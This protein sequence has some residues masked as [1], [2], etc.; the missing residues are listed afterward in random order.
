MLPLLHQRQGVRD[1]VGLS[2]SER[3][4]NMRDALMSVSGGEGQRVIIVDDITTSG[5]T[6]HAAVETLENAGWL[7]RGAAVV[8]D[9]HA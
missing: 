7:V 6:L 8:A 5:A 2:P 4:A 3:F 1:Q 9:A